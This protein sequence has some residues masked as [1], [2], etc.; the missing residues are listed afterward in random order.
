MVSNP[1]NLSLIGG[2][3][4]DPDGYRR[5]LRLILWLQPDILFVEIS[6]FALSY[7]LH[8]HRELRETLRSNLRQ[9]AARI[10]IPL[11][12]AMRHPGVQAIRRQIQLPF[13]YRAASRYATFYG[14]KLIAVDSSSFSRRWI[15]TWPELLAAENLMVL[16]TMDDTKTRSD[17][18][19][20]RAAAGHVSS[21]QAANNMGSGW[22]NRITHLDADWKERERHMAGRIKEAILRHRPKQPVYVGGWWHLTRG[23][24]NPTLRDIFQVP[25]KRCFLLP[26]SLNPPLNGYRS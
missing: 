18:H 24:T 4:Q 23:H 5:C 3:H 12:T 26:P 9:A 13:E 14:T 15:E 11:P 25:A 17:S 22:I 16:I 7:R 8:H 21:T 2:V 6:P 20:Y 19:V 1:H 10:G